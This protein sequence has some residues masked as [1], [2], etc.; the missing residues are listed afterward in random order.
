M[1]HR[2]TVLILISIILLV[3]ISLNCNKKSDQSSSVEDNRAVI[4]EAIN[5]LYDIA[6]EMALL[7][8]AV[9]VDQ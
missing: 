1:L 9:T 5:K 7:P 3:S 8:E 6:V 2:Q 4:E